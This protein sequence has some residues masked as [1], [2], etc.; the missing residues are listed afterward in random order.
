MVVISIVAG[1][2]WLGYRYV[3][4]EDNANR[5]LATA[6]KAPITLRDEVVSVQAGQAQALALDVPYAGS[7]TLEV[8]VRHGKHV[9]V[10]LIDSASWAKFTKAREALFGGRFEHYPAFKGTQIRTYKRSGRLGEG[11]YYVVVEN[12]TLGILV[13]S[14]FDAGVKASLRP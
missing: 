12:P 1:A 7:I 3:N 2:F 6:I 13:P 5:V 9:N 4:G 14:S 11:T 8:D 10:Y